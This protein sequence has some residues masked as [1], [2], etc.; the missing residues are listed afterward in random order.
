M[1]DFVFYYNDKCPVYEE[2]KYST[3]YWP[4]EPES[5]K[6]REIKEVDRLWESDEDSTATFSPEAAKKLIMQKYDRATRNIKNK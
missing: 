1:K 6:L 5:E 3:S 2:V 4:Q